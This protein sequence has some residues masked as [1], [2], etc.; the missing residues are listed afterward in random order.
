MAGNR[1]SQEA[2]KS[3]NM[4]SGN[5]KKPNSSPE[6]PQDPEHGP[7]TSMTSPKTCTG[8]VIR[9][10]VKVEG[11]SDEIPGKSPKKDLK[12]HHSA[13]QPITNPA[14]ALADHRFQGPVTDYSSTV[15]NW[16]RNRRPAHQGAY[17]GEAEQPSAS[18]IVDVSASCPPANSSCSPALFRCCLPMPD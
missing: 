4:K 8:Q 14:I 1:K 13:E 6:Q 3:G 7:E 16:M 5:N 9:E 12:K 18:Y 15:I 11:F 2:K 17:R 10:P